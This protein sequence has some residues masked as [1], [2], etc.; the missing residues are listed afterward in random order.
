MTDPITCPECHGRRGEQLGDLFLACQFCGG[1][2]WVGGDNEPA[3]R[4]H[5]EPPPPPPASEH[6]VWSDPWIAAQLGCRYCLGSKQ[7]SHIDEDAGTL[8]TVP[9]VCVTQ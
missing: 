8:V 7:V 5:G 4:G 9:C 6:K 3:E 1:R 2:G